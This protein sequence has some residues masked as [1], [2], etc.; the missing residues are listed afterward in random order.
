MKELELKTTRASRSD[1]ARFKHEYEKI[2]AL[3]IPGVLRTLAVTEEDDT[4]II[5]EEEFSGGTLKE[6]LSRAKPSL[7]FFLETAEILSE[8]T[9]ALHSNEITHR[10]IRPHNVLINIST[11]EI[12]LT[13]FGARYEITHENEDIYSQTVCREI[14]PYISPEQTGR[15]NRVIDYRTDLYS[16]G[17]T[18]YEFAAG[19]PPYTSDDPLELIHSHIARKPVSPAAYNAALPEAV[20][21]IVLT[22]LS[23]T[24][25]DRYQ[26]AYGVMADIHNCREQLKKTGRVELFELGEKDISPR[27]I[28]PQKLFGREEEI[29]ELMA[30]FD[31]VS[32]PERETA[33]KGVVMMLVSGAPGIGK[34][35]LIKEINKPIVAKRGYFI[36]GKYEQYGRDVPYS[37]IIQAFR[38][39]VR[40]I[41]SESKQKTETWQQKIGKALETLGKVV[42]DVIPE[43]ELII[44]RQQDV[45]ELNPE[46]ARNRFNIVFK[47]FIK[48]F[49]SGDH[50]LV[51][52]LDDLQ[53]ADQASLNFMR[54]MII[55]PGMESL[56]L[57]GAYRDTEV[58]ETHPL[59]GVLDEI[60]KE[61]VLIKKIVLAPLSTR[62]V[63]DFVSE[64][65]RCSKE[66]S[67]SLAELVH[68]KTGGNPFFVK[69]FMKTLYDNG[70]L[71][72]DPV[73]GWFWDIDRIGETNIT[74]NVVELMANKIDGLNNKAREILKTA[75]CIGDRFDL[76]TLS[77]VTGKSISEALNELTEPVEEGLI[78]MS[79]DIYSFQH[80][81]IMEAAYSLIP[82]EIKKE[83]HL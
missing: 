2:R 20:S 13:G 79:D 1:I 72:I 16:L 36:S 45:V 24:A 68:G 12:K 10:D 47:N 80:D 9:G 83:L 41:L 75:A 53:W 35:V 40:N 59:M 63:N 66:R 23:K 69:Q 61:E 7:E 28:L 73:K 43:V 77:A 25:E 74:A 57:I 5:E 37:A 27:F 48:V 6:F 58:S 78:G 32:H 8:I 82:E 51:L 81:R 76:K 31:L 22:L 46:E 52:F 38:G 65:L 14:L 21:N 11:G 44:G 39:L 60:G 71:E 26:N 64:V 17:I 34:S 18:L 33:G 4:I 3:E 29:A 49:A 50:P 56:L 55:D 67:Q 15:M 30:A 62:H 19:K 42:T 54:N 70:L